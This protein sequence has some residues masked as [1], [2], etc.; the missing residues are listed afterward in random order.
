VSETQSQAKAIID[1]HRIQQIKPVE[2]KWQNTSHVGFTAQTVASWSA[3]N[4][5]PG[6][7]GAA[8]LNGAQGSTATYAPTNN[9]TFQS[10]TKVVL[11]ITGDGDVIWNGK[12]SEA[13]DIL[14]KSFTLA[15]ETA[16]GVTKSARRRYY[17]KAVDNLAKKSE[18]MSPQDFVDFVRK[19]AYNRECKVLIDTLK[20]N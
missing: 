19:Q 15:V 20:G 2:F 16:K 7:N 6:A 9:I 11:T 3:Y 5:P 4:I 1:L 17:W 10:P 18:R 8:G 12:P 13:A 14:V